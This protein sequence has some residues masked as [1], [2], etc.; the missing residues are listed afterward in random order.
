[1]NWLA[2]GSCETV[3][4]FSWLI[5]GLAGL[6]LDVAVVIAIGLTP[7]LREHGGRPE[8]AGFAERWLLPLPWI[9]A[10]ALWLWGFYHTGDSLLPCYAVRSA[11]A[12]ATVIALLMVVLFPL[13]ARQIGSRSIW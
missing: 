5:G 10:A 12:A 6:L 4:G 11:V 2:T 7:R 9:L 13:A 3:A 8:P 1:M